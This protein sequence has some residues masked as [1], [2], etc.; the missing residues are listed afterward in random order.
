MILGK[1]KSPT[2]EKKSSEQD[3]YLLSVVENSTER[4]LRSGLSVQFVSPGGTTPVPVTRKAHSHLS[5]D[6]CVIAN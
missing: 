6:L 2:K 4:Q 3:Y 5:S 1:I